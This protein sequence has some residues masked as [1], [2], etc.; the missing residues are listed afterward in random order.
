MRVVAAIALTLT[1][2]P[3]RAEVCTASQYGVGDGYHGR[4]TASGRVFNTYATDPYTIARPSRADLLRRF[5]VTNLR[6]GASIEALATDLGPFIAGR[7]VDL[8][9]AGADAL[10]IGGLGFVRVERLD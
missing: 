2:F 1:A 10:G 6:N 5:R 8:G 9:R 4:R 7:C 3:A